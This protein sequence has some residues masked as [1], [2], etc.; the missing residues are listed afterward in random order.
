MV[1]IVG[2]DYLRAMSVPAPVAARELGR[3]KFR[4]TL[5]RFRDTTL[6]AL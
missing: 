4:K 3:R 1:A 2:I 6:A 5:S